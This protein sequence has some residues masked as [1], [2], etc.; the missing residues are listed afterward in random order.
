MRILIQQRTTGLF[1]K[2]SSE[3]TSDPEQAASF[4]SALKAFHFSQARALKDTE[5]V[6]QNRTRAIESILS[7]R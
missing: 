5:I 6:Y 2:N 1:F 7:R 3:W 4:D